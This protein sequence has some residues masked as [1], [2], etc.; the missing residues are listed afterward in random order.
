MEG[1]IPRYL[2]LSSEIRSQSTP[3]DKAAHIKYLDSTLQ[4]T[5]IC[6][7]LGANYQQSLRRLDAL[8]NNRP[9]TGVGRPPF[10][11]SMMIDDIHN[12]IA[13]DYKNG[14]CTNYT[15]L[16]KLIDIDYRN[17][18]DQMT[19]DARE[20]YPT[21]LRKNYVY[22]LSRQLQ[23][24]TK[25]PTLEEKDRNKFSTTETVKDFFNLTYTD[26]MI[27]G[28][29]PQ[30]ILNADETSVEVSLPKKVLIPDGEEEGKSID[31]FSK[32]SHISAM[33]TINANGDDFQPYVLVPLKYAPKDLLTAIAAG[34]ITIGGSPNGWMN[35]ICFEEWSK[36]L[37]QK[38]QNLRKTYNYDAEQKAIL[39]LD[40]HGSRNNSK[41]MRLFKS[42]F[43][44][45]I[46]FPPHMTHLFQPFDRVVA[47]P[48]KECLS[49]IAKEI[50]DNFDE[51]NQ[52]KTCIIRSS[53]IRALIDA[54][55]VAT[56]QHNCEEAFKACGLFPRNIN[57]ILNSRN[58]KKSNQ[59]FIQT[60]IQT[61]SSI[62]ISGL[63]ITSDEV[64]PKLR[65]KKTKTKK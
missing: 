1:Y 52:D 59:S 62:K 63:C 39:F 17:Q 4:M 34:K 51:E 33:I 58:V 61:A 40:G 60:D 50:I 32:S 45:V 46:I 65:G 9:W 21:N 28:V 7:E 12:E 27:Q 20:K 36:W 44:E 48:L 6:D 56:T 35:D 38:V 55:R 53:Q 16:R 2:L 8:K 43:I 22:E 18:I 26:E 24:N 64:L 54:H 15:Q 47:R 41:I 5:K 10:Y 30:L 49:R 19:P 31:K 3:E 42:N 23:L 14:D 13:K 37:I 11:N 57:K 29:P 25:K